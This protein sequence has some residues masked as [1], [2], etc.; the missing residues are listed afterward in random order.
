MR[1]LAVERAEVD[2]LRAAAEGR[3]ARASRPGACR[4]GSRCPRRSPCCSGARG[5]RAHLHETPTVDLGVVRRDHA[6]ELLEHVVL[7]RGLRAPGRPCPRRGYRRSSCA[8][9]ATA[10]ARSG[11]SRRPCAGRAPR[12]SRSAA[13]RNTRN[14]S[15]ERPSAPPPPRP[16]SASRDALRARI[17]SRTPARRSSRARGASAT[18]ARLA[19]ALLPALVAPRFALSFLR[20]LLE[21]VDAPGRSPNRGRAS[22][23]A[24]N[25]VTRSALQRDLGDVT[26]LGD[27]S[28]SRGHRSGGAD[29]S[30]TRS[31]FSSA[32]SRSAGVGSM[33]RKVTVIAS[34]P[35]PRG[36]PIAGR[37]G[38]GATAQY[39]CLPLRRRQDAHQ[40]AVLRHRPAGDVD[41]LL[42]EELGDL[43]VAER[44]ARVLLAD[45]LADLFL[46]ALGRD[47]F[48]VG[49]RAGSR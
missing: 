5:P 49:R 26:P 42:A 37:A 7:R 6:R 48:A 39:T 2:A 20:L 31:S 23:P 38:I 18:A 21:L 47:L 15:L 44:L 46:H 22:P 19:A 14:S 35:L 8:R 30:A 24:A 32:Y 10:R 1:R 12:A 33:C 16:T 41:V 43:L 17:T 45:D 3:D 36:R 29:T 9:S 28:G 27:A 11:R 40:L 34:L 25:I 13:L 4:A